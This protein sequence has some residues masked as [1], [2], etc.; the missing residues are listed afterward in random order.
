MAWR[1]LHPEHA[2]E[3]VRVVFSFSNPLSQKVV[4]RLR[5]TADELRMELGLAPV[6]EVITE[7]MALVA[8]PSGAQVQSLMKNTGWR[9]ISEQEGAFI[10]EAFTLVQN[11]LTYEVSNYL[12]WAQFRDRFQSIANMFLDDILPIVDIDTIGLEYYDR[13]IFDGYA[14][15][16]VPDALL[17][18]AKLQNLR[19]MDS[20]KAELFHIHVG[21]FET[22]NNH[23]CLINQNVDAQEG[24]VNGQ[25]ARS[26][27]ILTKVDYKQPHGT[28]S[29]AEAIDMLDC[30]HDR[31][32]IVFSDALSD[33]AKRSVGL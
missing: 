3:R 19:D 10:P 1:P 28:T 8:G 20:E 15:N 5:Q 13:F 4:N 12:R 33:A 7:D 31:S 17:S 11:S 6:S 14:E 2:I 9:L 24:E 27:S 21:W 26:I 23:R 16:A 30:L 25:K 32:K 22:L 18:H 29:A